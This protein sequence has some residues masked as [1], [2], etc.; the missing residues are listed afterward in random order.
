MENARKLKRIAKEKGKKVIDTAWKSKALH[1]QR[2]QKA[3]VDLHDIHSWL[4]SAGLKEET[5][6][7]KIKI[8]ASSLEIFRLI[9][10]IMGLA[11]DVDSVIQTRRLL[12]TSSH[13][14]LFLPPNEYTNRQNQVWQYIHWQ[15]CNHYDTETLDK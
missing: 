1:G 7:F 11:L 6:R 4:R 14:A 15:I 13:G 8:R 5:E 12:T 9:F 3:D 10:F 2:S